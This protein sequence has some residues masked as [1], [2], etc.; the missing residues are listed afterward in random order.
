MYAFSIYDKN[1]NQLILSRDKIGK[2]PLYYFDNEFFIW[3]SE[4]KIFK[5]SPIL[6]KL[7]LNLNALD[8]FFEVGY[9]PNPLSILSNK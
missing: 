2:K 6:N 9:I 7:R 5:N 3:G 4:M 8:N 1:K